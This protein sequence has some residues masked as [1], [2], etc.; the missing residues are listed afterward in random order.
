VNIWN[1]QFEDGTGVDALDVEDSLDF[2]YPEL[3]SIS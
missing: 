2:G 3:K 1:V